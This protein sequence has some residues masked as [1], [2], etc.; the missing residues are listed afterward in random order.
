M[1]FTHIK[2]DD[3]INLLIADNTEQDVVCITFSV[4]KSIKVNFKYILFD[5]Y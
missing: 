4:K 2:I 5:D 3:F 1:F